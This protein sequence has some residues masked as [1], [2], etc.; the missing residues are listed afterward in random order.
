VDLAKE[1]YQSVVGPTSVGYKTNI[2][3]GGLNYRF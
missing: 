2:V 1:T 3:R